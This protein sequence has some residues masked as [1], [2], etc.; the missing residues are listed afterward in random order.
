MGCTSAMVPVL[1]K[2]GKIRLCGNYKLT[3]NQVA[4]TETC[5]LPRADELFA[6]L[7]GGK[8]FS[9]LDLS[10]A[11]LQL[12]LDDESKE[13]QSRGSPVTTGRS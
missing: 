3:I 2:D 11:Y 4:I 5:P 1:K 12:P 13:E 7:S 10:S 6:K 8:F 9:K